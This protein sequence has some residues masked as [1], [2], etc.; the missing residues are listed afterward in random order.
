MSRPLL[1]L[2][3]ICV[4]SITGGVIVIEL[5][6]ETADTSYSTT[7]QKMLTSLYNVG[8]H[9]RLNILFLHTYLITFFPLIIYMPLGNSS[10]L[11]PTI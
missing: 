8:L 10:R 4:R 11:V 6:F 2:R 9:L 1:M 7:C 5:I 3:L